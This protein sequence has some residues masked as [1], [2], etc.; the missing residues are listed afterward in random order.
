MCGC[1]RRVIERGQTWV[2]DAKVETLDLSGSRTAA[3][4]TIPDDLIDPEPLGR[5][6]WEIETALQS[7]VRPPYPT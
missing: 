7:L 3:Q 4:A 2:L 5:G 1:V 6:G